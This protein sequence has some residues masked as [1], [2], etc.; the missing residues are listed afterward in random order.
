MSASTVIAKKQSVDVYLSPWQSRREVGSATGG[1]IRVLQVR[2]ND[3]LIRVACG[4]ADARWLAPN[5]T[6]E[7]VVHS[8]A[9]LSLFL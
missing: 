4:G 6:L 2:E 8:A 5:V 1:S 7:V 3:Y 9:Y